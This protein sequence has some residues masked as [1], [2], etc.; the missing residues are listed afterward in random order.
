MLGVRRKACVKSGVSYLG[1]RQKLGQNVS[2]D[3]GLVSNFTMMCLGYFG[4]TLSIE[5]FGFEFWKYVNMVDL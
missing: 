5:P 3:F 2:N 4:A 1:P